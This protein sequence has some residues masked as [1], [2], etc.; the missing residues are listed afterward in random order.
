MKLKILAFLAGLLVATSASAATMT[1]AVS[2]AVGNGA[3]H[4]IYMNGTQF[5]FIGSD[6]TYLTL[7]DDGSASLIGN[8]YLQDGS[9]DG[10]DLTA[11]FAVNVAFQKQAPVTSS[12]KIEFDGSQSATW[13]FYDMTSPATLTG[14]GG[15]G[16]Y[17]LIQKP[18]SGAYAFQIG[19]GANGKN[20]NFGMSG[21]F[22]T[23]GDP[24]LVGRPCGSGSVCDFN[25]DL[26][27][28]A[29][30]PLPAGLLLLPAGLAMLGAAGRRKKAAA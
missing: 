2:S 9:A 13:D 3:D 5:D 29:P 23:A 16:S 17:D 19:L 20:S 4:S 15:F 30:V 18:L 12:P 21:W 27:L 22:F 24:E 10:V 25:L 26:E 28:V 14:F 8:A 11:G 6:P 1:Y 7:Y